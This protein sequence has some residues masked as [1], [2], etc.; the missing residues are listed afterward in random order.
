MIF[1][2]NTLLIV[3][4]FFTWGAGWF[5]SLYF[6]C[7]HFWYRRLFES[8]CPYLNVHSEC[9]MDTAYELQ[10]E[11]HEQAGIQTPFTGIGVHSWLASPFSLPPRQLPSCPNENRGI[12][13]FLP[14]KKRDVWEHGESHVFG[15]I[16]PVWFLDLILEVWTYVCLFFFKKSTGPGGWEAVSCLSSLWALGQNLWLSGPQFPQ[17]F[18][19]CVI[20]RW[21][22][23]FILPILLKQCLFFFL[24]SMVSTMCYFLLQ[25]HETV[26]SQW[27]VSP[28]S[29]DK[30]AARPYIVQCFWGGPCLPNIRPWPPEG[31][32]VRSTNSESKHFQICGYI[33]RFTLVYCRC[34]WPYPLLT[35]DSGISLSNHHFTDIFRST[36][37]DCGAKDIFP[38][39][40]LASKQGITKQSDKCSDFWVS[41]VTSI[42]ADPRPN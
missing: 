32:K 20:L 26:R 27:I 11:L 33:R 39:T 38:L 14:K 42:K 12:L 34:H 17:L 18:F 36:Y 15:W 3:N 16:F 10:H 41:F 1:R 7:F 24:L 22:S 23:W 30:N 31:E 25:A 37:R 2:V 13:L 8:F 4:S 35:L 21:D 5:S 40:L 9:C 19:Y 29:L 6:Y 28:V